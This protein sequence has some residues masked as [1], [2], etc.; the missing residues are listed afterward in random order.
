MTRIS[1]GLILVLSMLSAGCVDQNENRHSQG[2]G[3]QGSGMTEKQ[4]SPEQIAEKLKFDSWLEA[5]KANV[6]DREVVSDGEIITSKSGD[7]V[8][9]SQTRICGLPSEIDPRMNDLVP[10]GDWG[11][12]AASFDG[13]V[14]AELLNDLNLDLN[15]N[16]SLRTVTV[17]TSYCENI[18]AESIYYFTVARPNLEGRP[19]RFDLMVWQKRGQKRTRIKT[20][21]L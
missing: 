18:N 17:P 9:E 4:A 20:L 12:A 16:G 1:G 10:E 14:I 3:G 11:E 5:Q 2:Q 8:I 13:V 7:F 21:Y 6:L 15:I 19:Y